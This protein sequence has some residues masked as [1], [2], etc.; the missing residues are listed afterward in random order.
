MNHLGKP[1]TPKGSWKTESIAIS[2]KF[3]KWVNLKKSARNRG[4]RETGAG[5]GREITYCQFPPN[6][7][8]LPSP[9]PMYLAFIDFEIKTTMF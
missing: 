2:S 5:E 7:P 8:L 1:G 3:P 9:R 4:G 6:K